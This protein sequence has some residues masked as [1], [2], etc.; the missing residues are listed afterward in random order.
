MYCIGSWNQPK[1]K[2]K[3]NAYHVE[4]DERY[5]QFNF[6]GTRYEQ[7]A[8]LWEMQARKYL[9]YNGHVLIYRYED[10]TADPSK[11]L[12]DFANEFNLVVPE[13]E[14]FE[15]FNVDSRY[16][17]LD[18]IREAVKKYCVSAKEFGYDPT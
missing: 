1:A 8:Q 18:R 17:N 13:V 7:Q 9:E 12:R 3:L 6:T 2:G 4:T 11:P 10:W 14:P 16:E 5:E 15:N